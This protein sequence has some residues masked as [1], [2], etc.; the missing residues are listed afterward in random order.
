MPSQECVAMILAGGQ[1]SRLGSLTKGT[2]K[3]AVPFGGKHRIIDF[4][5]SNCRNSA[6]YTVGVLTQYQPLALHRHIGSGSAWDLDKQHGG[7]AILPPY[8]RERSAEWYRGTADAIYQN[9]HFIEAHQPT[10]VLV[11]SGDHI[12]TMDYRKMLE[13]HKRKQAVATIGV[14]RIPWED[15]GRFGIMQVNETGRITEFQ[16]KPRRTNSNLASMGIYIFNWEKLRCYLEHD[17]LTERSEHDFGKN[18]IP[19]MLAAGEILQ[20]Y[21][22]SGYWKDVGTVDSLW[23][24]NMD[25]LG[26]EPKLDLGDA[27]WPVYSPL[28]NRQPHFIAASARVTDS[29]INQGCTILGEVEHCV[30]SSGAYIAEG[31]RVK[32]SVLLPNVYIG[33]QAQVNRAIID[34]QARIDGGVQ[35]GEEGQPIVIAGKT[36]NE[37]RGSETGDAMS[38]KQVG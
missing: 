20:S 24:A 1:G 6:I 26:P 17:A 28:K 14:I 9:I 4:V 3:P 18:I 11:L 13:E 33:P 35:I 31:A 16:E 7:V 5:L 19:A 8:T 34:S 37:A 25:L 30:V 21:T 29:L 36:E 22:Y 2:A 15:T 23:E 10:Y 12:Y 27:C 38:Q 32:N